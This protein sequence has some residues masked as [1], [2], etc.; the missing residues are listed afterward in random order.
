MYKAFSLNKF[1]IILK[2][3]NAALDLGF[4]EEHVTYRSRCLYPCGLLYVLGVG[5]FR[6]ISL[7][8]DFVLRVGNFWLWKETEKQK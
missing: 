3:K 6:L 1:N 4:I 2:K 5:L 8:E 7:W